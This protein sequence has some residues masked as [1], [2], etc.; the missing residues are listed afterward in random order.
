MFLKCLGRLVVVV[1]LLLCLVPAVA[2]KGKIVL[3]HELVGEQQ[4]RVPHRSTIKDSSFVYG[5][6]AAAVKWLHKKQFLLASFDSTVCMADTCTMHIYVGQRFLHADIWPATSVTNALSQAGFSPLKPLRPA[7]YLSGQKR[8]LQYFE[9]TGYP[10]A[11]LVL[12]S[13][14]LEGGRVRARLSAETGERW[15]VGK[16]LFSDTAGARTVFLYNQ[17][18]IHPGNFYS[19]KY[20]DAISERIDQLAFIGSTGEPVVSFDIPG[21]AVLTVPVQKIRANS[22]DGIIGFAPSS[23]DN[24]KLMVTGN[25]SL[26]LHNALHQ[27]EELKLEWKKL[28]EYSQNASV[29]P[30]IKYIA[31]SRLGSNAGLWIEKQDTSILNTRILGQFSYYFKGFSSAG[32][33]YKQVHSS[34]ISAEAYDSVS[35]QLHV[36]ES[37]LQMAGISFAATRTDRRINPQKGY[38]LQLEASSGAKRYK[39]GAGVPDSVFAP[40]ATRSEVFELGF[41]AELF[42]PLTKPLVL[43]L[44]SEGKW[45]YAPNLFLNE[46]YRLGGAKSLRGFNEQSIYASAFSIGTAE[47]RLLFDKQSNIYL[48]YNQAVYRSL[49]VN[50]DVSDCPLGFGIGLNVASRNSTFNITYA[51]GRQFDG[52]I[53]FSAGKIHFGLVNRF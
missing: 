41:E 37:R 23:A 16:V 9:D 14:S 33:H 12:D 40:Y 42:V 11:Q 29:E 3:R 13:L 44:G 21:Y 35:H 19:Q 36:L 5:E 22:F 48:F 38:A 34:L 27:G 1:V 10:F 20:I 18:T 28:D 52:P 15:R 51:V 32:V 17:I 46:L 7:Q 50:S 6:A 8:I 45:L 43:M 24:D 47:L 4:Y 30:S 26:N 49:T 31:G 2:A 53:L 39:Q 25:I